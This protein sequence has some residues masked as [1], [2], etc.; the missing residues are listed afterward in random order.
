M[1]HKYWF[2]C[3]SVT[4]LWIASPTG[5][6]D[7]TQAGRSTTLERQDKT[8]DSSQTTLL[9]LESATTQNDLSLT[10]SPDQPLD[11]ERSSAAQEKQS[12]SHDTTRGNSVILRN[13]DYECECSSNRYECFC[14]NPTG[15]IVSP[16]G[17]SDDTEWEFEVDSPSPVLV[18]VYFYA[19]DLPNTGYDWLLEIGPSTTF[20]QD[21]ELRNKTFVYIMSNQTITL[22]KKGTEGNMMLLYYEALVPEHITETITG[23]TMS[24]IISFP[25]NTSE[26]ADVGYAHQ[27]RQMWI[28]D[29]PDNYIVEL[30]LTKLDLGYRQADLHWENTLNDESEHDFLLIGLGTEIMQSTDKA[31]FGHLEDVKTIRINYPSGH[32]VMFSTY[33]EQYA[34]GFEISYAALEVTIPSSSTTMAPTTAAP[35][36]GLTPSTLAPID[37]ALQG[38][39]SAIRISFTSAVAGIATEYVSAQGLDVQ[40]P[41]TIEPSDVLVHWMATCLQETCSEDCVAFNFSITKLN[42][43]GSAWAFTTYTLDL[44]IR[45]EGL[46]SYWETINAECEFCEE[47]VTVNWYVFGGVAAGAVFLAIIISLVVWKIKNVVAAMKSKQEIEEDMK[48]EELERRRRSSGDESVIGGVK[49]GTRMSLPFGTTR[50]SVASADSSQD[51]DTDNYPEHDPDYGYDTFGLGADLLKDTRAKSFYGNAGFEPDTPPSNHLGYKQLQQAAMMMDPQ[52]STSSHGLPLKPIPILKSSL[53]KRRSSQESDENPTTL[54]SALKT[55]PKKVIT[56][57]EEEDEDSFTESDDSEGAVQFKIPSS[58]PKKQ[59][60]IQADV[61]HPGAADFGE[62]VL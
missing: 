48:Q 23:D 19:E 29:Y 55:S 57:V 5:A 58:G 2:V 9:P 31:F 15:T 17:Y 53:K 41:P 43:Q 4:V 11:H 39:Y 27:L 16:G 51:G 59:I 56:V 8:T 46:Q 45:D 40:D 26:D 10:E 37:G 22:D 34:G 18:M 52:P 1:R 35:Q 32:I 60:S 6:A 13:S 54:S 7:A 28:L 49:G 61:H 12:V 3:V 62:T 44:M 24:G 30:N 38:N 20:D 21:S 50:G 47:S 36:L 14:R 42:K 33:H 25:T